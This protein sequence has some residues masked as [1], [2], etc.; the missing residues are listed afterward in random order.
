MGGVDFYADYVSQRMKRESFNSD[1]EYQKALEKEAWKAGYE[2]GYYT[3]AGG[4]TER[5]G[6]YSLKG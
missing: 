4:S 3:G 1:A 5:S 2:H 6:L